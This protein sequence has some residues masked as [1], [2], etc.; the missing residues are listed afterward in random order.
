MKF[1]GEILSKLRRDRAYSLGELS[2]LL[3]MRCGHRVSRSAISQWEHGKTCPRLASLMAL[4]K[5]FQVDVGIFFDGKANN[6][7]VG[8]QGKGA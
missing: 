7:F 3:L 5:I 2:R 1:L 8:K 6:L 4:A